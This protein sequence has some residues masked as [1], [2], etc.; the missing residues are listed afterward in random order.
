MQRYGGTLIHRSLDAD[1]ILE[2]VDQADLRSLHF[3]T[4]D[5]QSRMRLVDATALMLDYTRSML[6]PLLFIDNP[7]SA[8]ILGLGGGSLAKFLF[9]YFPRCRIQVV[10]KRESVIRLAN[11]YFYLPRD[12]RMDVYAGDAGAYLCDTAE[13]TYELILVDLFSAWGPADLLTDERFFTL[14]RER[15]TPTGVVSINLWHSHAYDSTDLIATL[16][17]IFGGQ[18]LELPVPGKYNYIVMGFRRLSVKPSPRLLRSRA[19]ALAAEL[20]IE[21]P[22]LLRVLRRYNRNFL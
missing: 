12:V 6:A 7:T 4:A 14:C 8:L 20:N 19:R 15:L 17:E 3:G 11:A 10:E 13:Q 1:G 9:H 2:I 5:L 16:R 21:F 22:R 18:I